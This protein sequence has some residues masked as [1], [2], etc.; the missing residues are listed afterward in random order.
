MIARAL[1]AL[2]L[3]AIL[4][5]SAQATPREELIFNLN[6]ALKTR[7]GAGLAHCFNFRGTDEPTR[8]SFIKIISRILSWPSFYLTTSEREG[9]GE[10]VIEQ[11]GKP[12]V[13]NGDWKYQVH[14]LPAQ[15]SKGGYVFPAGS[16]AGGDF[17]LVA[18]PKPEKTKGKP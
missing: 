10:P 9:K 15:D 16:T 1:L 4:L 13:L 7:D 18:V 17:I 12:Y 11:G 5:A 2:A 8:Q 14:I 6:T 3:G